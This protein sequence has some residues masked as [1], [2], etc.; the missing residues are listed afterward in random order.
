M[1]GPGADLPLMLSRR[2]QRTE[3]ERK[4]TSCLRDQRTRSLSVRLYPKAKSR[5]S[6]YILLT[7]GREGVESPL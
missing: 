7:A 6:T 2:G 5:M 3:M 1:T 4:H